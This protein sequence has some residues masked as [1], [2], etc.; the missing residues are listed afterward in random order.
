[1]KAM[2]MNRGIYYGKKKL[3]CYKRTEESTEIQYMEETVLNPTNNCC[4]FTTTKG[5]NIMKHIKEL[6]ITFY[7]T[8]LLYLS[9]FNDHWKK[10]F[11]QH[12]TPQ[13]MHLKAL[14][15]QWKGFQAI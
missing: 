6:Y 3:L 9:A 11:Q 12:K 8:F 4:T 5:L 1:M 15:I 10:A 7:S 2:K 13:E 14:K